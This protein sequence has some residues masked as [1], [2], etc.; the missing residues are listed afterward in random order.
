[1]TRAFL[2]FPT[3]RSSDLEA[4]WADGMRWRGLRKAGEELGMHIRRAGPYD[5]TVKGGVE[6]AAEWRTHRA[7]AVVAYN[8]VMAVGF[9][10]AAVDRKSTR[11]HSS[12]VSFS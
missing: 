6:A 12:H 11:L 2:S 5:P 9:M 4:S 3:R 7:S 1:P 8:D 10:R